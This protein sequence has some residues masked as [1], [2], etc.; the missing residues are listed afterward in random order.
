MFFLVES[1][2]SFLAKIK[3]LM[4]KKTLQHTSSIP[5]TYNWIGSFLFLFVCSAQGACE[6]RAFSFV[7]RCK[8]LLKRKGLLK[9]STSSRIS[10]PVTCAQCSQRFCE[11]RCLLYPS[12]QLVSLAVC[13]HHCKL[14]MIRPSNRRGVFHARAS[15]PIPVT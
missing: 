12:Q 6:T 15:F 7:S 10:I 5:F 9:I 1:W 2:Q 14:G 8:H 3:Q 4:I 13:C 11:R